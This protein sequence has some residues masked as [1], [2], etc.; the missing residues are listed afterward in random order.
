MADWS[1][2][3]LIE[4]IET[5]RFQAFG[6]LGQ[7]PYAD[8]QDEAEMLKVFTN[9]T[10]LSPLCGWIFRA[11]LPVKEIERKIDQALNDFGLNRF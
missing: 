2:K 5:N 1:E 4:A 10:V 7:S 3:Q 11:N 6:S 9:I 8:V